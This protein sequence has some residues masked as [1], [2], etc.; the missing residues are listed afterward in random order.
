MTWTK[1][2]D[3]KAS[4]VHGRIRWDGVG[5]GGVGW[6]GEDAATV[7]ML[8]LRGKCLTLRYS[9][10]LSNSDCSCARVFQCVCVCMKVCV[11]I[12][13]RVGERALGARWTYPFLWGGKVFDLTLFCF[14]TWGIV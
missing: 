13:L 8:L 2:T 6:A 14:S 12:C 4:F 9:P 10:S 3:I 5:W 1:T 11:S 7:Q